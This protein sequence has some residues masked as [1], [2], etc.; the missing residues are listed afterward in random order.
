MFK[1]GLAAAGICAALLFPANVAGAEQLSFALSETHYLKQ[2]ETLYEAR[3]DTRDAVWWK[4]LGQ[5]TV[6]A[7][8]YARGRGYALADDD[9]AAITHRVFRLTKDDALDDTRGVIVS[10]EGGFDT[11]LFDEYAAKVINGDSYTINELGHDLREIR[12]HNLGDQLASDLKATALQIKHSYQGVP[13]KICAHANAPLGSCEASLYSFA[14]NMRKGNYDAGTWA[15]SADG[16]VHQYGSESG[17]LLDC[18]NNSIL[19]AIDSHAQKL[20]VSRDDALYNMEVAD[21]KLVQMVVMAGECQFMRENY[22]GAYKLFNSAQ[23]KLQAHGS[24]SVEQRVRDSLNQYL[25]LLTQ[26]VAL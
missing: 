2:G 17:P 6:K 12:K 11:A 22:D 5:A 9:V 4:L 26:W 19:R 21:S 25:A 14:V 8:Q 15:S 1:Q 20:N 24:L 18:A 10:L 7:T 13:R 16:Y 3:R 23:H